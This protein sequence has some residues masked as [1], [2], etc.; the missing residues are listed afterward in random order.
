MSIIRSILALLYLLMM[1]LLPLMHLPL[2]TVQS[3]S[4]SNSACSHDHDTSGPVE[5]NDTSDPL[6]S[7]SLCK[8]MILAV[9]LPQPLSVP[10]VSSVLEEIAGLSARFGGSSPLRPHQARAPPFM[11]A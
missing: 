7:C 6:H 11:T 5:H 9:D 1:V 4:G 2:H 8:L 10:N 3:S